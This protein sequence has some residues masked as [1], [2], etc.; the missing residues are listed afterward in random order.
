MALLPAIWRDPFRIT[1]RMGQLMDELLRDFSSFDLDITPAFGRSDVYIKD[2]T[3]VIETELPGARKED[4]QVRVEDDRLIISGEVKRSEEVREDNYIRMGRTYG[5]FRRVFPL[6]DEIEDRKKIKA[7][8][9]NGVLR[10]EVPLK[11]APE[12]EGAFEIKVE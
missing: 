10:V 5:A 9:E 12:A 4:V 6:P 8:F 7:K 11:R 2:K 3:L 1:A